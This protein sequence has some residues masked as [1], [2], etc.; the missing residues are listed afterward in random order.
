M[1]STGLALTAEHCNK[2]AEALLEYIFIAKNLNT[3]TKGGS[4]FHI[5]R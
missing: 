2:Y 1:S 3:Y 4:N 5:Y